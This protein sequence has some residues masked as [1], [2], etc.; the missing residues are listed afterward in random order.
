MPGV[1]S[2][3]NQ[4]GRFIQMPV[5]FPADGSIHVYGRAQMAL[6]EIIVTN[7]SS[8]YP[9][10]E[11]KYTDL[12]TGQISESNSRGYQTDMGSL[13]SSPMKGSNLLIKDVLQ[14]DP[15]S[16]FK[17]C[18]LLVETR[19]EIISQAI[20]LQEQLLSEINTVMLDYAKG[21]YSLQV[22]DQMTQSIQTDKVEKMRLL[23]GDDKFEL[24]KEKMLASPIVASAFEKLL[25]YPVP[26]LIAFYKPILISTVEAGSDA[27]IT[28][29]MVLDPA[30]LYK[31]FTGEPLNTLLDQIENLKERQEYTV[32]ICYDR[33]FD[34]FKVSPD[35]LFAEVHMIETWVGFTYTI[36]TNELVSQEPSHETPQTVYLENIS[37]VWMIYRITFD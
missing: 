19:P 15:I 16:Y 21:K 1:L 31:I 36:Q 24:M 8:L 26:D 28:A 14:L 18:L 9:D 5:E 3:F 6:N 29:L 27:E 13:M 30:P 11:F 10:I 12:N 4:F 22:S 35:S 33:I 37:G 23:L 34:A 17:E 2:R 7:L 25:E 32:N 20:K